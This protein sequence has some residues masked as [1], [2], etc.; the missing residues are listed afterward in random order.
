MKTTPEL[1]E[2]FLNDRFQLSWAK[3]YFYKKGI[4]GF[5]HAHDVQGY[6]GALAYLEEMSTK[7]EGKYLFRLFRNAWSQQ[8]K[9]LAS[10]KTNVSFGLAPNI[11]KHLKVLAKGSE[12]TAAYLEN[13]IAEEYRGFSKAQ[14]E[15]RALDEAVSDRADKKAKAAQKSPTKKTEE[16][17]LRFAKPPLVRTL[18]QERDRLKKA[19]QHWREIT[20]QLCYERACLKLILEGAGGK[21]APTL[22][23]MEQAQKDLKLTMKAF[24]REVDRR[25]KRTVPE[26]AEASDDEA[27]RSE[28]SPEPSTETVQ[29]TE[30]RPQDQGGHVVAAEDR[31][32][33]D[34]VNI[35]S[36]GV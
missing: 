10:G 23:Q 15:A 36:A 13:L 12:S 6:N 22:A 16:V 7:P 3:A 35:P 4:G 5:R 24:S 1:S 30:T 33:G 14:R 19:Q 28:M 9:R 25:L 27:S 18:E 21:D 11:V 20:A 2:W 34:E 32:G 8:K 31:G 26:Q 29:S 17:S